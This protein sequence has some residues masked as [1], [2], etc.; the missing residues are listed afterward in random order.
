VAATPRRTSSTRANRKAQDRSDQVRADL[1]TGQQR[2]QAD[3]QRAAQYAQAQALTT[4]SGGAHYASPA[5]PTVE[6]T[7]Q[8]DGRR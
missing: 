1:A 2:G 7:P 5:E 6:L 4:T 3:A 8:T